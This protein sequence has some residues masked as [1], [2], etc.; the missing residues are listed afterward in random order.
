MTPLRTCFTRGTMTHLTRDK[1][2][3]ACGIAIGSDTSLGSPMPIGEVVD[4]PSA[5]QR[6][7]CKQAWDAWVAAGGVVEDWVL[8]TANNVVDAVQAHGPSPTPQER[9]GALARAPNAKPSLPCTSAQE[10][11]RVTLTAMKTRRHSGR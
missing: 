4:S 6:S 8:D 1:R 7:G 9:V 3:T 5:C 11:P 10:R 2:R